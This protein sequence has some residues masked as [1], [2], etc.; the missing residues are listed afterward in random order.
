MTEEDEKGEAESEERRRKKRERAVEAAAE[1]EQTRCCIWSLFPILFFT[2]TKN[3]VKVTDTETQI[4]LDATCYYESDPG[5]KKKINFGEWGRKTSRQ[6]EKGRNGMKGIVGERVFQLP[7]SGLI[8]N[9]YFIVMY[10]FRRSFQ[11][12]SCFFLHLHFLSVLPDLLCVFV[13]ICLPMV[14]F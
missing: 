11:L 5:W 13:Y 2:A 3:R 7:L 10:A 8:Y 9:S 14:D 6:R 4:T 12:I 1:T